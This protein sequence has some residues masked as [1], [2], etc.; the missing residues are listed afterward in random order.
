MSQIGLLGAI[1]YQTTLNIKAKLVTSDNNFKNVS[2]VVFLK[3]EKQLTNEL[4]ENK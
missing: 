3:D 4:E 1:I 2:N